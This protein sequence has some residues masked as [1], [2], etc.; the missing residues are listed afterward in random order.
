MSKRNKSVKNGKKKI[1]L[2]VPNL[3]QGGMEKVCALTADIL[4]KQFDVY[5]AI[6]TE[7]DI[8]YRPEAVEIIN[9]NS[10]VKTGKI[11]KVINVFERTGK[12]RKIKKQYKID[13][14]M[15]F[16][17]TA[18]LVNV[19]TMY[20]DTKISAIHGYNL[21]SEKLRMVLIG[22]LSDMVLCCSKMIAEEYRQQYAAKKVLALYN[23][24]YIEDIAKRSYEEIAP[25]HS[26]FFETSDKMIATMSREDDVKGFWHLI[27]LFA[28]LADKMNNV[29]MVIIGDGDFSEYKKLARDLKVDS[30]I[31]F[32]GKLQNPFSYLRLCDVYVMTSINEGLPNGL[33]EA[34]AVGL[35]IVSANCKSG[36]SEI[37][38]T[39]YEQAACQEGIFEADFGVLMPKLNPVKNVNPEEI[40]ENERIYAEYL[41]E[42]LKDEKR[43][44]LRKEQSFE[45]SRFFRAERYEANLLRILDGL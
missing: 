23:P 40:E 32:A 38:H 10:D 19:L 31:L 34:M 27:K 39:D 21:L 11:K 35:P 4:S 30:K 14:T 1:L 22:R 2:M 6:F 42:F 41:C 5:L 33:I 43:L 3:Q 24:Y 44:A 45:R 29:R 16:G 13:I 37:L 36:P 8:F 17:S 12:I 9:I 28:V 20:K 25:K 15:S 7:K 26:R 18:S